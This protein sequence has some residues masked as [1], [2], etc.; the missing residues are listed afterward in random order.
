MYALGVPSTI[1]VDDFLPMSESDGNYSTPFAP[2]SDDKGVWGT[3]LEKAFAK[4]YGNYFHTEA[5]SPTLAVRTL[6]GGPWEEFMHKD[7]WGNTVTDVEDLWALLKTH[8]LNNEI[9]QAT[10]DYS[11]HNGLV[12]GHAYT[13]IG[14]TEAVPGVRLV[15]MRNPWG[16]ELYTGPYCDDCD[17]WNDVSQEIKDTLSFTEDNDGVFYMTIEDYH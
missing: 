16:S 5:G 3:I 2:V 15:K 13:T 17:E 14:V 7:W 6:V 11:S 10:T 4:F 8:D 9:I 1:L 12:N